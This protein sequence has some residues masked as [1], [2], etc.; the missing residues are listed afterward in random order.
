MFAT[1]Q[2]FTYSNTPFHTFDQLFDR[3]SITEDRKIGETYK[4]IGPE[5]FKQLDL[6]PRKRYNRHVITGSIHQSGL[7]NYTSFY[8]K[9]SDLLVRM[10]CQRMLAIRYDTIYF[11]AIVH[12]DEVWLYAKNNQII[13]SGGPVA[14]IKR[15]DWIT[16]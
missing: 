2:D 10:V 9:P 5:E 8:V 1:E 13:N 6:A 12:Q 15:E 4:V 16:I 7:T 3:S 11:D 14:K